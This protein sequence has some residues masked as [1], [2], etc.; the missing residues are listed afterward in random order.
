MLFV[1]AADK[2]A[3]RGMEKSGWACI[4]LSLLVFPIACLIIRHASFARVLAVLVLTAVSGIISYFGFKRNGHAKSHCK[5][6]IK[7]LI[8]CF[9][10]SIAIYVLSIC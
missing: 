5:S 6:E 1:G 9:A 7:S 10:C 2:L 8:A 4:M 3:D